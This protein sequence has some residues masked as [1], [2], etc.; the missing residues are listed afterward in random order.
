METRRL[1]LFLFG[2]IGSRVALTY[3]AANASS[4]IMPYIATVTAIIAIGFTVIYLFGLRATGPEV[5]GERIWWND[6][7]PLHATMYALFSIAA[8]AGEPRAWILL[9]VDTAIGLTAFLN[10]H[11]AKEAHKKGDA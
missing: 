4:S 1:L 9:A 7:R 10:H 6:L 8:F 11:F 5:F 3:A 2:C